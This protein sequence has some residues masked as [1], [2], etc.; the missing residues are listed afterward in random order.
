MYPRH[1]PEGPG[2]SP[3]ASWIL[4]KIQTDAGESQT[5]TFYVMRREEGCT[6]PLIDL[7]SGKV[8][9]DHPA[10]FLAS[11]RDPLWCHL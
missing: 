11:R 7:P 3:T 10:Y 4:R 5:T 9:T 2:V 1:R 8:P 6:S